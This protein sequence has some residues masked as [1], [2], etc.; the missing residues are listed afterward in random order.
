MLPSQAD[1]SQENEHLMVSNFESAMAE[2]NQATALKHVL[3]YSTRTNGEKAPVTIKLMHRYGYALYKD[4]K[5]REAINVL[6]QT[7]E[8][9][10][11]VFGETG[12]VRPGSIPRRFAG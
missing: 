10:A 6:K 7:L 3:E 12:G 9:T 8:R 11:E 1:A 4:G 5:Y 2:G